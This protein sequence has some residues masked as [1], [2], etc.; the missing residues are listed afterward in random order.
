MNALKLSCTHLVLATWL[1]ALAPERAAGATYYWDTDGATPGFGDVSAVFG[2]DSFLSTNAAGGASTV[3]ATTPTS[4]DIVNFG[5]TTLALGPT[6]ASI[7]VGGSV[8]VNR[9]NFGFAQHSPAV[10]LSAGTLVFGGTSPLIAPSA[11]NGTLIQSDI[12]L[13]TN[14]QIN[15]PSHGVGGQPTRLTINGAISGPFNVTFNAPNTS[16]SFGSILL[17]QKSTYT[18]STLLQG[19]GTG[20]NLELRLGIEDA[21]PPTTVLTLDGQNGSN[22]AAG[23]Y[24]RLD[25]NGFNQTLAGLANVN[26]INVRFQQIINSSPTPAVLTINTTTNFTYT[27]QLGSSPANANFGLTK[28]GP[29]RFTL[30][31]ANTNFSSST[32]LNLVYAG[33]TAV[34]GGV[35]E[36]GP[37]GRLGNGNYA[38][39]ITI[40]AGA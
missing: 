34:Q 27:G 7:L 30:N 18:G 39:D 1:A 24:A 8:P 40:A 13:A 10:T 3:F 37:R 11:T 12:L 17:N 6:A 21:L 29:G 31:P 36:I 35:L 14:L 23:R 22:S 33:P 5:T 2:L 15:A 20:A 25:L 16:N 19:A 9:I 32:L 28:R 26:R 38:A 4:A